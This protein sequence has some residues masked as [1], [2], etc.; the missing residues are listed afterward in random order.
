MAAPPDFA[1]VREVRARALK[2]QRDLHETRSLVES[3]E[4]LLLRL[5]S[6][7]SLAPRYRFEKTESGLNLRVID[8][9]DIVERF[10]A[11]EKS[12]LESE[13]LLEQRRDTITAQKEDLVSLQCIVAGEEQRFCVL[14]SSN[15]EF[16]DRTT[17][18]NSRRRKIARGSS[19][20]IHRNCDGC[21]S[22]RR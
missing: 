13:K 8:V 4:A 18:G 17:Q 14:Y 20:A 22:C 6:A 11:C 10:R 21:C 5:H 3:K 12:L 19:A 9:G 1:M 7:M 16:P 2:L 15:F